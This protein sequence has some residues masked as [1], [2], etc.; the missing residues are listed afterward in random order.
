QLLGGRADGGMP[1]QVDPARHRDRAEHAD[2][3]D[4]GEELGDGV[5]GVVAWRASRHTFS[6]LGCEV[7]RGC[8]PRSCGAHPGGGTAYFEAVVVGL[9]GL[10]G[11]DTLALSVVLPSTTR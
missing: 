10:R 9:R 3:G 11:E 6:F 4:D 1:L 8:A 5:A 2:D 7:S